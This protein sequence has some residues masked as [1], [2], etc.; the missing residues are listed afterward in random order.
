MV[1]YCGDT[2]TG[3]NK[4]SVHISQPNDRDI[5]PKLTL[6]HVVTPN[7]TVRVRFYIDGIHKYTD[8]SK[9]GY[10]AFHWNTVEYEN[11]SF[12]TLSATAI[13]YKGDYGR[14]QKITVCVD[15]VSPNSIT[16]FQTTNVGVNFATF[17]WI[18]SGDDENEGNLSGYDIR[19]SEKPIT[20]A[21]WHLATPCSVSVIS[22]G[23]GE[24]DSVKYEP[25]IPEENYYFGIKA[26]D[27]A[28]NLSALSNVIELSTL[29]HF[30]D[31]ININVGILPYSIATSDYNS[32]GDIDLAIADKALNSVII[33]RNMGNMNF[34]NINSYGTGRNPVS[35]FT[36]DLNND[37]LADLAT[38]NFGSRSVS[39]LVNDG[40]G[41]FITAVDYNIGNNPVFIDCADINNDEYIDI[42]TANDN[43]GNVSLLLNNMD[44][45]FADAINY[46]IG[47]HPK[48]I[49]IK[50]FNNDGLNDF[51]TSNDTNEPSM[52]YFNKSNNSFQPTAGCV[53][54]YTQYLVAANFDNDS[55]IDIAYI[56]EESYFLTLCFNRNG[57]FSD[58]S[59]YTVLG[60]PFFLQSSDLD[61]DGDIDLAVAVPIS[62]VHRDPSFAVLLNLGDGKFQKAINYFGDV[63]PFILHVADL[64][65]DFYNDII[66]ADQRN[67]TISIYKNMLNN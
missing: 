12:H 22:N 1:I 25:L 62:E 55:S 15:N 66:I 42:M 19:Y 4:L 16:D 46:S 26:I 7:N 57:E 40:M 41:G 44:G 34:Q 9:F 49:T 39:V 47:G 52:I 18:A 59:K 35:I 33:L 14:T 64:D 28:T 53:Q 54:A 36:A 20:E 32:D 21:N 5:V 6:I 24:I 30:G 17:K 48:A 8:S 56:H 43:S 23:P 51:A 67:S 37:G 63:A 58:S 27:K 13:D 65:N 38:A 45:T 29:Q 11:G 31:P 2:P 61:N 50:D 60:N 3:S 10:F